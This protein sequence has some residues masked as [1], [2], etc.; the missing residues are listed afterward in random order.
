MLSCTKKIL[1]TLLRESSTETILWMFTWEYSKRLIWWDKVS[2]TIKELLQGTQSISTLQPLKL[3]RKFYT[4]TLTSV[5]NLTMK[6]IWRTVW[7]LFRIFSNTTRSCYP[8][9]L[10][11]KMI[12]EPWLSVLKL[13]TSRLTSTIGREKQTVSI[14]RSIYNFL[15]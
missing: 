10:M 7:V 14:N 1:L 3:L 15:I 11:K 9:L 2:I 12:K 8:S 6:L 13:Q 5:G 4:S